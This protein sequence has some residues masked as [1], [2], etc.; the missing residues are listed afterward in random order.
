MNAGRTVFSQLMDYLPRK[1]FRT[2]VKRYKGNYRVRKLSCLEQF[3]AMAFAQITDRESLRDIEICLQSIKRYHLG[4]RSRVTRNT[5]A[6]ANENRD[7]RIYR[8][9]ACVLIEQA[10]KLYVNTPLGNQ[11]SR[12]AYALDSTVID[13]SLSLFPWAWSQQKKSAVKVHTQMDLR[14]NIPAFLHISAGITHDL[15]IFEHIEIEPGSFYVMDKGYTSF[16]HLYRL[17]DA[18]AYFV[19]PAKSNLAY[20]TL[21]SFPP[22]VK[23][24]IVADERIRLTSEKGARGYPEPLRKIDFLDKE[25][26]RS[27]VFLSNNFSLGASTIARLYKCRWQIELFFKWIKQHLRIKSF[28]GRSFNAVKTQIWIA[29][30]VYVIVAI[31]KKEYDLKPSLYEVLRLLGVAFC[32]KKPIKELF[33]GVEM[34]LCQSASCNQLTL[35]DF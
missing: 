17:H 6:K 3:Y 28:F 1:R 9:I 20:A 27:L 12:T 15:S 31:V 11:L 19:I 29:I 21:D 5:L 18:R 2:C 30:C 32:V 23:R 35:F 13:L 10:R 16:R 34:D 25:N 7:W 33:A 4:F 22:P 26:E 14:G 8:D 24:G